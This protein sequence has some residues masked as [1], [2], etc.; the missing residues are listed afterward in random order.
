[1]GIWFT[2]CCFL[3]VLCAGWKVSWLSEVPPL[4]NLITR[5]LQFHLERWQNELTSLNVQTWCLKCLVSSW[6]PQSPYSIW[7][8]SWI[9]W[10]LSFQSCPVWTFPCDTWESHTLS[11]EL[12]R[13][14]VGC[15]S[16]LSGLDSSKA[17]GG[18]V[19][20]QTLLLPFFLYSS[21]TVIPGKFFFLAVP[22]P[23]WGV[24]CSFNLLLG[25]PI[26]SWPVGSGSV[27]A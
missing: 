19:A 9:Y 11:R 25:F 17:S 6:T 24:C 20:H 21:G 12:P 7:V 14:S 2:A 10:D 8:S 15:S 22:K 1:M 3:S 16:E 5:A 13:E 4:E 23:L 18:P 26:P 27:A